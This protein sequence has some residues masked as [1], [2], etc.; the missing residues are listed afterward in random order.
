MVPDKA[1]NAGFHDAQWD[2][3]HEQ[4]PYW[5][6]GKP[7][8]TMRSTH[9]S[10]V[11]IAGYTLGRRFFAQDG[12]RSETSEQAQLLYSAWPQCAD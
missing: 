4:E 3:E 11:Y 8:E 5:A 12:K 10:A 1:F 2:A 6:H 7:W 9:F